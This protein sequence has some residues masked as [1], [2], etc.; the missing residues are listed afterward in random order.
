[1]KKILSILFLFLFLYQSIG[2]YL[3]FNLNHA[4][5]KNTEKEI[6]ILNFSINTFRKINWKKQNKEFIYKG[7]LYDVKSI[8]ITDNKIIIKCIV[9]NKEN[10]IYKNMSLFINNFVA[11]NSLSKNHK[12]L[13]L[14][15][16]KFN[17]INKTLIFNFTKNNSNVL[18]FYFTIFYKNFIKEVIPPPPKF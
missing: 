2:Y 10:L 16:F 5:Y 14:K 4:N 3:S 18:S 1:M 13:T 9:D 7:N 6:S 11:T 12:N 17:F 8:K 15:F